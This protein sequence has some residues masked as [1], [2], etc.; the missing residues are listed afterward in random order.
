MVLTQRE[1]TLGRYLSEVLLFVLTDQVSRQS[2]DWSCPRSGLGRRP[3]GSVEEAF[4]DFYLLH[5]E[6]PI[7]HIY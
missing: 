3:H 2:V 1:A 4:Q 7:Q 5:H 6:V